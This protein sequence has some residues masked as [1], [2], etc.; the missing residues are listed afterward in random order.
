MLGWKK[1][2]L[3]KVHFRLSSR[4]EGGREERR[5]GGKEEESKTR[6]LGR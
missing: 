5:K 4:R 3:T 6:R 1:M 2:N